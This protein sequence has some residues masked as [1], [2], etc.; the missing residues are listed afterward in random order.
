M[1]ND[2]VL[3]RTIIEAL[4]LRGEATSEILDAAYQY[5]YSVSRT[6]PKWLDEELQKMKEKNKCV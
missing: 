3:L 5:G 1:I 2:Q 4:K 6:E